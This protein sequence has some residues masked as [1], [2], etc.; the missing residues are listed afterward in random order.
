M[1]IIEWLCDR[2]GWPAV[3]GAILKRERER[4]YAIAALHLS[5]S[6]IFT[7]LERVWTEAKNKPETL[8]YFWQPLQDL[9]SQSFK[10]NGSRQRSSKLTHISASLSDLSPAEPPSPPVREPEA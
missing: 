2:K 9:E 1:R 5:E 3:P 8:G 7:E 10:I 4:G 6:Q